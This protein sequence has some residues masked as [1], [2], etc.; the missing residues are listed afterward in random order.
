[1][2]KHRKRRVSE[3]IEVQSGDTVSAKVKNTGIWKRFFHTCKVAKIPLITLTI[4][5]VLSIAQNTFLVMIPQV[6]ANFFNG[7][8]SVTSVSMFIGAEILTTVIV[9]I[10]LYVDHLFRARTNRNLRNVLWKK[11]LHLKPKYYDKVSANTLLSRITIDTE[12]FNEFILDVLWGMVLS[13]YTLI[14]TIKEMSSISIKASLFLLVF[15]PFSVLIAFFIG[16]LNLKIENAKKY[17]MSNLTDYLSELV[18][19]LPIVKAFNRQEYESMRGRKV[20]DDY[21]RSERNAIGLDV[22]SQ[23]FGIILSVIPDAV[24]IIIG[25]RLLQNSSL[26]PA[27]WY[28]FYVYAGTLL[29]FVNEIG[30][31][32][33]RTKAI[34]GKVNMISSILFEEEEGLE[35]YV[36]DIVESG[37]L[38]FDNV[39]FSYDEAPVLN[40]ISFTIPKDKTTAIVGYSGSGKST[41]IKLIERIYDPDDGRILLSGSELKDY[42]IEAWRS[43]IAYVS[44]NSPMISGTVRENILYGIKREVSDEEIMQAAKMVYLDRFIMKCPD[45]LEHQVGQFG[46]K[47]SGGQRQKISIARAILAHPEYLILDEPTASLDM[48]SANEIAATVESLHG[49]MTIIIVAHQPEIIKSADHVIVLDKE[50]SSVEGKSRE[51]LMSND[52]Y[53]RLM[54]TEGRGMG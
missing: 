44:Q 31:F 38:I 22:L 36:H 29:G 15:V 47:L 25:V 35:H 50:H 8:A 20:I 51:L 4:F 43:R 1:M 6:N 49:Q 41:V 3:S 14:L 28:I 12:S 21:Y 32:W 53:A 46:S 10:V 16:R 5:I 39:S 7:D 17:N 2:E 23:F 40:K 42:S 24:L 45:G 27:G 48:L 9:Q 34:Q 30:T 37:D 19:S 11:I 26:T 33:Q 13:V 18:S 52:F 54:R